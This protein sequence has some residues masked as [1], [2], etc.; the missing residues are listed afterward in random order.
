MEASNES[1]VT[2]TA[3][4]RFWLEHLKACDNGSVSLRAYAQN[5]GLSA[6]ALYTARRD[7]RR[8]GALGP[9][10]AVTEKRIFLP[11]QITQRT[12]PS[13]VSL[14]MRL[15]NGVIVELPEHADPQQ[16]RAVLE[17]AAA[18]P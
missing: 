5:H 17:I 13:P 18:L 1:P 6:P 11:V 4:Q 3:R 15:R 12:P 10:E 2:L 7:L 8:R 16:T 14:R 9:S